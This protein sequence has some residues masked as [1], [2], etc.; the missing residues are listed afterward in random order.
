[1]LM[2]KIPLHKLSRKMSKPLQDPLRIARE[3]L[4]VRLSDKERKW[5]ETS[6]VHVDQ[7]KN[8]NNVTV[9]SLRGLNNLQ[10]N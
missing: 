2:Q 8:I 1:M 7:E 5:E 6:R 9:S 4:R 10:E 3:I